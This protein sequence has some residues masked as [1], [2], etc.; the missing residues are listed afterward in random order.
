MLVAPFTRVHA[1]SW[2][3]ATCTELPL[4]TNT[5]PSPQHSSPQVGKTIS[6]WEYLLDR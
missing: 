5:S 1:G 4:T 6:S 3:R 2:Q